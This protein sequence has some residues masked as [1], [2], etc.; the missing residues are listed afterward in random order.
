MISEKSFEYNL[1]FSFV[2][3]SFTVNILAKR[4]AGSC[5]FLLVFEEV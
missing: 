3:F 1:Y 5:C 4:F 2:S